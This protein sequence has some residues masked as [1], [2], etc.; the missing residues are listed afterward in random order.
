MKKL[1]N[2]FQVQQLESKQTLSTI[3]ECHVIP[4]IPE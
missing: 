4:P 2:N 3:P 1:T